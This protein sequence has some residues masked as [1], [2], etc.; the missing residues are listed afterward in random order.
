MAKVLIVEDDQAINDLLNLNLCATGHQCFQT[1]SGRA[2]LA[3][4]AEQSFDLML[5]DIMLP[6]ME[7]FR[8]LERVR[9]LPTIVLTARGAAIDKM[10]GFGLGADDYIVKPFEVAELLMRVRAV[11]RRTQR[12]DSRYQIDDLEILFDARQV[13]LCGVPVELTPQEYILLE[14]LVQNRNIALTRSRL[15]HEAWGADFLGESRT[16]DVH[17][18]K[19]RKKLRLESRIKTVWKTG[20]RFED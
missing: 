11:L 4:C 7:G 19:L 3:F 10:R 1:F 20:Y 16:V 9:D 15:L 12:A 6:D 18:Q 13:R 8:I 2:A 14:T 5:L 17:I